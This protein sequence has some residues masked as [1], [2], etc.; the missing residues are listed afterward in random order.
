MHPSACSGLI[1]GDIPVG[2]LLFK[3]PWESVLVAPPQ[4]LPARGLADRPA[5][6]VQQCHRL[7]PCQWHGR[8]GQ[9]LCSTAA[10]QPLH[11]SGMPLWPV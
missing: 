8:G 1:P 9:S 3:G 4:A 5:G 11:G 7:T 6:Q 2:A 10:S